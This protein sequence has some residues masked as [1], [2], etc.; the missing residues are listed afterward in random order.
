[1]SQGDEVLEMLLPEGGWIITGND[2]DGIQFI[3]SISI[4]REQFEDGFAKVDAWKAK[5]EA[6]RTAEKSALLAKLGITADEARL[7]LG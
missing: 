7:L 5:A 6:Q 3:E 2:F 4:T 1:M